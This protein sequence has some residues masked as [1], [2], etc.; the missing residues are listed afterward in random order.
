MTFLEH[1][2]YVIQNVN[3]I[4]FKMRGHLPIFGKKF[5]FAYWGVGRCQNGAK[6][7]G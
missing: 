5:F 7:G 1:N 4:I 2:S 3:E 6:N